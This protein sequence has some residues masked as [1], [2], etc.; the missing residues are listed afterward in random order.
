MAL[1]PC[2]G[3]SADTHGLAGADEIRR[4]RISPQE[5]LAGG[6]RQGVLVADPTEIRASGLID[7]PSMVI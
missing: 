4:T 3:T 7:V 6:N 2:G 5:A 1:I